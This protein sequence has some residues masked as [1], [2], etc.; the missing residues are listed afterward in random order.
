MIDPSVPTS[1]SLQSIMGIASM[2]ALALGFIIALADLLL[3]RSGIFESK[4]MLIEILALGV[5]LIFTGFL[6]PSL[7][8]LLASGFAVLLVMWPAAYCVLY[9]TR[10]KERSGIRLLATFL[11]A[12]YLLLGFLYIWL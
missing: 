5:L 8:I 10:I 1:Q 3:K 2:I 4:N 6:L 12:S 7:S 11:F 9:L